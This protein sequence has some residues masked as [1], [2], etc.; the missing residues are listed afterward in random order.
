MNIFKFSKPVLPVTLLPKILPPAK[1]CVLFSKRF[2]DCYIIVESL[3]DLEKIILLNGKQTIF[4]AIT[5]KTL[6]SVNPFSGKGGAYCYV[7]NTD[8][9]PNNFLHPPR[10]Q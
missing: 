7:G 1:Y 9:L 5:E 4:Q 6:Q 2:D 3:D 8:L 10:M